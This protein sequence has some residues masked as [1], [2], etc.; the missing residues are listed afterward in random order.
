MEMVVSL[1]CEQELE[2]SSNLEKMEVDCSQRDCDV[3]TEDSGK[4][5]FRT[6]LSFPDEMDQQVQHSACIAEGS[7]HRVSRGVELIMPFI[8][9]LLKYLGSVIRGDGRGNLQLEFS[10]LSK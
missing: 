6:A 2:E 4:H 7:S 10:L 9:V 3:M 5:E 1:L 8:P